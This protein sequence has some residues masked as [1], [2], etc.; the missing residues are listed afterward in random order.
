MIELC[1]LGTG[2]SVAT[3]ERDN[4][5]FFIKKKDVFF[6]VDCPG[7][8][9]Q[10]IKKFNVDPRLVS[11]ILVT[12]IHPDHIYGLPSLVHSLMMDEGLI[13]LYGSTESVQ[14]CKNLLDLFHLREKKVKM[15]IE[16]ITLDA[17]DS[18]E[19]EKSVQS[20]ALKVPHSPSSLAFHFRFDEE[21]K[22]EIVVSSHHLNKIA[23]ML[24]EHEYVSASLI[25]RKTQMT[26]GQSQ[27]AVELLQD[28]GIIGKLKKNHYQF[29]VSEQEI[30]EI[31]K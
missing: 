13:R 15:R 2:G 3:A 12:H 17:G 28:F 5:S 24:V 30:G 10:K 19:L 7:G 18:F 27:K 31:L 20:T 21:E 16:F 9:F 6:L 8:V 29:M 25:Q 23:H 26:Y 11:A 14:L 4:T 1:F 22:A